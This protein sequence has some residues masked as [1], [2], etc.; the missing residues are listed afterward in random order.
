VLRSFRQSKDWTA[1]IATLKASGL[2]GLGGAGFP[3]GMK[4]ELVRNQPGPT[5]TSS[6][7]PTRASRA[8]SRTA[9]S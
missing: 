1:L 4:W 7:T 3:T 8:R 5:S 9:T 6:A 2:R